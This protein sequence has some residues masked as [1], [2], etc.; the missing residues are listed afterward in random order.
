MIFNFNT[1]LGRIPIFGHLAAKIVTNFLARRFQGSAGYWIRRYQ[2]GGDSGAGSYHKFA[3]F[4]GEILNNFVARNRVNSVIEYGCGDGN[5]LRL[6]RYPAYIGFDISDRAISL[7]REM[8]SS[9]RSKQFKLMHD[10]DGERADLTISLDVIYHLTED[11]AFESYM[12]RLFDSS[13][14]YVIIYS[15]D[16]GEQAKL[17]APHVKHRK[18]TQWVETNVPSWKLIQYIPNRFPYTGDEQEGSFADFYIYEKCED[19]SLSP[20]P[21]RSA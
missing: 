20:C 21:I 19:E 6:A 15:S 14:R 4:K 2:Q 10:Y 3:E 18:F 9:H 11:D 12:K 13:D 7:C 17:Q 8:F 1:W 5:Q 16:T